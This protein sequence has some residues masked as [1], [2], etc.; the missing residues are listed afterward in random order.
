MKKLIRVEA[1][2]KLFSDVILSGNEIQT[3]FRIT[4]KVGNRSYFTQL[5]SIDGKS[6]PLEQE[7]K[8]YMDIVYGELEIEKFLNH[9]SFD[10]ISWKKLGDGQVIDVKDIYIETDAFKEV[11]MERQKEIMSIIQKINKN[12]I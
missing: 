6:I 3:G 4:I 10:F 2:I 7:T 9:I 8:V 12:G 5:F 1:V 11:D